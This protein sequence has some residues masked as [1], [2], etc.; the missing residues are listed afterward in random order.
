MMRLFLA[1]ATGLALST[2]AEAGLCPLHISGF[3]QETGE[4][5]T[6]EDRKGDVVSIR[7]TSEQYSYARRDQAGLIPLDIAGIDGPI[8]YDWATP[9][10]A[11]ADLVPGATFH[12]EGVVNGEGTTE[13]VAM[14]LKVIGPEKLMVGNCPLDVLKIEI[15]NWYEGTAIGLTTYYLHIPSLLTLR[16]EMFPA[17]DHPVISMAQSLQ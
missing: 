5:L 3:T 15:T 4:V 9:L 2:T 1:V 8:L 13:A 16:S 6:V 10:P 14:D 12:L 17:D 11:V 7:F